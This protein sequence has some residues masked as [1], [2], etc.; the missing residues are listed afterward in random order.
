MSTKVL[1]TTK[2]DLSSIYFEKHGWDI[3]WY[4]SKPVYN[5]K[6]DI[7]YFRDPFNDEEVTQDSIMRSLTDVRG[8]RSIDKINT[9]AQTL[10][11]EDKYNQYQTY[12]DLMPLTFLPSE[13]V[14]VKG[15]HL[16]KKRISQRSK[17]VL[18]DINNV[19]ISDDWIFQ[20]IVDIAEELRVYI[21]FGHII[22]QASIKSSK[23]NG[24]V[25]IIGKR[26]LNAR[27]LSFC[28]KI[29]ERSKLDFIGVDIAVLRN[30]E[31]VLIE[32]NRSP[33]FKKYLELYDESTLSSILD[34]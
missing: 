26:D 13:C 27:E 23:I 3:I 29:S 28:Q 31:I 34:I 30:G 9:Y 14:F 15:K 1:V 16:A 32:V 33:Q 5:G 10:S 21:V 24:K 19:P 25:K 17:D 11:F 18:F 22:Q 20:E 8:T 7:V 12:S 2:K 6:Y 4:G